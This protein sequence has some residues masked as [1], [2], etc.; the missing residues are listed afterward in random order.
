MLYLARWTIRPEHRDKAIERFSQAGA[1]PPMGIR[2]IG[3]WHTIDQSGGLVIAEANDP[4]DMGRWCL[5]WSDIFHFDIT[6]VVD[7]ADL[8]SIL[9]R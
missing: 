8:M 6:P 2:V 9:G 3:R 1:P 5:Q 4:L 7:D